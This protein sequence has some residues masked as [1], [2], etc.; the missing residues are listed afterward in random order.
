MSDK[1]I[2]RSA[3][4]DKR[5]FTEL[6]DLRKGIIDVA[7]T[8]PLM[9][10][11]TVNAIANALHPSIQHL[12]VKQYEEVTKS[13]VILCLEPDTEAGT[14]KLAYF[15]PGQKIDI[16]NENNVTT[17]HTICSSPSRSLNN[18]YVIILDKTADGVLW[19]Y[20][21]NNPDNNIQ[22]KASAPYGYFH[23]QAIRD[24]NH[25]LAICDNDGY[26]PFLSMAESVYDGTLNVDLTVIFTARKHNEV[27]MADRFDE[28]SQNKHVKFVMVLS[29]EHIFKCERGF[30]TK[31]LIEKYAPSVKYS[32]FI[33]GSDELLKTIS[34]HVDELKLES[35]KIRYNK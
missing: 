2:I 28:L 19:D 15:R 7:P 16:Y 18:E 8:T 9:A 11:Y 26:E 13:I 22:L 5:N 1:I 12:K 3:M 14:A 23:Y 35:N 25:I 31:S 10:N 24:N 27:L 29:D 6:P 20:V 33:S 34:P 30:I 17:T 32:L 4:K 21:A